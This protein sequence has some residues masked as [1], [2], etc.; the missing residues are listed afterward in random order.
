MSILK[1]PNKIHEYMGKRLDYWLELEACA[2]YG[3]E[4]T[5]IR[6]REYE[7]LINAKYELKQIAEKLKIKPDTPIAVILDTIQ[8]MKQHAERYRA[9]L[10]NQ[11]IA[12]LEAD[13]HSMKEQ[14]GL[15]RAALKRAGINETTPEHV[16]VTDLATRYLQAKKLSDT[17]H[18]ILMGTN[19]IMACPDCHAVEGA[20]GR[21]AGTAM[22][23]ILADIARL[24]DRADS[25]ARMLLPQKGEAA[26]TA[27][28][29]VEIQRLQDAAKPVYGP[30]PVWTFLQNNGQ[31]IKT[32]LRIGEALELP[33]PYQDDAMV[34]EITRL[35][36]GQM[37]RA[38]MEM[39]QAFEDSEKG[40]V[41]AT[42]K[43]KAL[44]NI[45][46]RNAPHTRDCCPALGQACNCWKAE[47]MA[48]A[49]R[50]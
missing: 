44:R 6:Y 49:D 42:R 13:N 1:D 32:I 8:S 47:F 14:L 17:Q 7:R 26:T 11:S 30:S 12:G 22:D 24:K 19:S 2:G 29:M 9:N 40:R 28:V 18:Q 3:G 46:Q 34:T 25:V 43:V 38:Y 48:E 41:E 39:K 23:V 4:V 45:V 36:K 15:I 35:Q 27:D 50:P 21:P 31:L 5:K 16:S 10:Q 20:L 33:T 37:Q